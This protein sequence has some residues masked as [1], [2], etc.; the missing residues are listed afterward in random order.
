[1][2]NF[3]PGL[4]PVLMISTLGTV[5]RGFRLGREMPRQFYR[6][7]P[8]GNNSCQ[9]TAPMHFGGRPGRNTGDAFVLLTRQIRPNG[10][11]QFAIETPGR[12]TLS[13]SPAVI[14]G[15][16]RKRPVFVLAKVSD[17]FLQDASARWEL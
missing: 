6:V 14:E 9:L 3:T 10:S 2:F 13:V 12:P 1:M 11:A 5:I 7:Q 16:E 4:G 17:P 15:W 8:V